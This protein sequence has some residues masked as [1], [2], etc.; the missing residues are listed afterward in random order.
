MSWTQ[1]IKHPKQLIKKNDKIEVKILEISKEDRKLSL[2]I[3]QLHGDSFND[4]IRENKKGSRA[5]GRVIEINEEKILLNL[6]EGVNGTLSQ[7][8]FQNSNNEHNLEVDMEIEILIANINE[9]K[10]ELTLSIR[11]LE[12]QDERNALKENVQKNKEIE[13]ASKSNIGDMIKSELKEKENEE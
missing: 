8:D 4:Y 2:G 9:E 6:A 11:A 7:K 1:I 10:R 12:K 5:I 13:E 3:K